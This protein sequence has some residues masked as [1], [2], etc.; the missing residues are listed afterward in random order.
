MKWEVLVW[1]MY[2][3]RWVRVS[4]RRFATR[5]WA[6]CYADLRNTERGFVFRAFP[7]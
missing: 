7:V 1:S 6:Q 5:A 2:Q 3:E 4:I